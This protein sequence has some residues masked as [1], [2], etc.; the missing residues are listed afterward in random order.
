ML[1]LH[2]WGGGYRGIKV[3]VRTGGVEEVH[4]LGGLVGHLGLEREGYIRDQLVV[5]QL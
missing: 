1:G 4:A 2:T 3:K 5:Q